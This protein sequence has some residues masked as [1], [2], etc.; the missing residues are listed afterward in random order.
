MFNK[1]RKESDKLN[2][3]KK[4]VSIVMLL[5]IMSALLSIDVFALVCTPSDTDNQKSRY[6][7]S[8]NEETGELVI[9]G[10]GPF[11]VCEWNDTYKKQVKSV[12]IEKGMTLIGENAFADFTNLKEI[13]I[14]NS[15]K[16]IGESAFDSCTAL[17]S[18]TIPDGVT[19]IGVCAFANCKSLK[20][21]IKNLR[22]MSPLYSED[23]N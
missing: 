6:K 9:S 1:F 4:I 3:V 7:C 20:E 15:V 8:F 18:I 21:I 14:P 11:V 19:R 5:A 22:A 17:T 10:R 16:E 2:K 13:T 12:K 23:K